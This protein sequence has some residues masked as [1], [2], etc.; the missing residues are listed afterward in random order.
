M[1]TQVV[2]VDT[3]RPFALV[4]GKES[5]ESLEI[6]TAIVDEATLRFHSDPIVFNVENVGVVSIKVSSEFSQLDGL[7]I[8][9]ICGLNGAYC[10][11]C[12]CTWADAVNEEKISAGFSMDRD[13]QNL[14]DLF[15]EL[16]SEN[17]DGDLV[18]KARPNDYK[19]RTGLSDKPII[20]SQDVTKTLSVLH[21]YL[22]SLTFFEQL[23]YHISAG[24]LKMGIG[25]RYD[26]EKNEKARLKSAKDSF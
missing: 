10:T 11:A 21:A 19:I 24:V 7:A 12:T 16:S 2:K 6:V 18:I 20:N 9:K 22:R 3:E 23:G 15:G 14:H 1:M 4:A 25:V 17:A 13:V 5:R 26:Q 8:Q